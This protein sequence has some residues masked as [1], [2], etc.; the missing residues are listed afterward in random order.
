MR[1][2]KAKDPAAAAARNVHALNRY[3]VEG[4]GV[5]EHKGRRYLAS[6]D[7]HMLLLIVGECDGD[8]TLLEG[9]AYPAAA[10]KAARKAAP[11][12]RAMEWAKVHLNEGATVTAP[13]GTCTTFPLL[14]RRFPTVEGI[15]PTGKPKGLATFDAEL[16]VALQ[17]GLGAKAIT[18][19]YHGD[20]VPARIL[21]VFDDGTVH[22]DSF[23]VVMPLSGVVPEVPK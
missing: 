19:E 17:R 21:P 18:V 16:L 9:R 2:D 10:V 22:D 5:V 1:F 8:D 14:D 7:G 20:D 13:D 15:V 3:A 4:F 6:T 11:K 23:G 12:G